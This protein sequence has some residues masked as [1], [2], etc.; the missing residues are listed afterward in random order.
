MFNIL[1][2]LGGFPNPDQEFGAKKPLIEQMREMNN[3]SCP[4]PSS[5]ASNECDSTT[6]VPRNSPS[7][8]HPTCPSYE[9][10]IST[11][12]TST[13]STGEPLRYPYYPDVQPP[14]YEESSNTALE[15]NLFSSDQNSPVS[16]GLGDGSPMDVSSAISTPMV[17]S[18]AIIFYLHFDYL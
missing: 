13:S 14:S 6:D 7:K 10:I 5:A 17:C 4:S 8:P 16:N 15:G 11:P 18:L 12:S 3:E 2:K 9:D 1:F